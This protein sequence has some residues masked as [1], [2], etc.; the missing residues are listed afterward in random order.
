VYRLRYT[1]QIIEAVMEEGE[2]EGLESVDILEETDIKKKPAGPV[3]TPPA[4]PGASV[5]VPVAT[6]AGGG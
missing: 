1:L 5:P 4:L 6:A 2:G 3:P